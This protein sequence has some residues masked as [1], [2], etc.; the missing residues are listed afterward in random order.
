LPGDY[1]VQDLSFEYGKSEEGEEAIA[2]RGGGAGSTVTIPD[3][4]ADIQVGPPFRLGF[5]AVRGAGAPR[6]IRVENAFLVGQAGERYLASVYSE[7]GTELALSVRAP[8]REK[9]LT[10]LEYG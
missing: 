3:E 10:T 9:K 4:A 5:D 1:S 2:L 6:F 8:E 7:E